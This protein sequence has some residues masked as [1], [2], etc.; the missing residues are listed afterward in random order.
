M[1]QIFLF[2]LIVIGSSLLKPAFS[3]QEGRPIENWVFTTKLDGKENVLVIALDKMLWVAYDRERCQ[4]WKAWRGGI[5]MEEGG[6]S[7]SMNGMLFYELKDKLPAWK[8]EIDGKLI[9]P[10]TEMGEIKIKGDSLMINYKLIL[11]DGHPIFVSEFPEV[12]LRPKDDN[13]CGLERQIVVG[14]VSPDIKVIIPITYKSMLLKKDIRSDYKE[15]VIDHQ[16]RFFPWGT[17]HDL[18]TWL[19]LNPVRM[20]SLKMMYT[21][22]LEQ[23]GR[24]NQ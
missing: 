7:A 8:V 9:D 16:K 5:K 4:L 17:I 19:Y 23:A 10:Q 13:R 1:K 14:N 22:N 2:L 12:I 21:F 6:K 24:A 3:Q 11:P 15:K 18:T 20:T